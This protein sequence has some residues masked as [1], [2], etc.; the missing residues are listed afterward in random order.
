MTAEALTS[1]LMT[2]FEAIAECCRTR[3]LG[4]T[5]EHTLKAAA[6]E[7]L[8][9][10]GFA[11]MEGT[12]VSGMG[13]VIRLQDGVLTTEPVPRESARS[14]VDPAKGTSPD[15]RVWEPAKLVF[16]LQARSNYGSQDATNTPPVLDDLRRVSLGQ[17]DAFILAADVQIYDAMRGIKGSNK[18][19]PLKA[20][21]LL[22]ALFPPSEQLEEDGYG[23]SDG[24]FDGALLALFARRVISPSGTPRIVL[25]TLLN[26]AEL[27][28]NAT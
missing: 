12:S 4:N 10:D 20:P 16:E 2:A 8:L 7:A 14:L 19:R 13:K 11:V 22:E 6:I 1:A 3:L 23:M 15:I 18:G 24:S 17:V 28:E 9:R 27:R 5:S 21:G 25:G 26:R